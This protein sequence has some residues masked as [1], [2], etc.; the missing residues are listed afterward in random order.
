MKTCNFPLVTAQPLNV[1]FNSQP[2]QLGQ[3]LG[4]C[5]QAVVTGT[6]TGTVK[7]QASCDPIANSLIPTTMPPIH[8]TD[9]AN[10]SFVLSASGSEMW[11]VTSSMY[12]WV[13]LVYTDSSGGTSTATMTAIANDKG[14]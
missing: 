14:F 9:V 8:W 7:L 6:P 2:F 13:R 11:N 10:S 5:I 3:V 1:S 12:T 4:Y